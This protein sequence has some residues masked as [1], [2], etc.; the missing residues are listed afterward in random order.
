MKLAQESSVF[1]ITPGKAIILWLVL[2]GVFLML[3]PR[4]FRNKRA[5]SGQRSD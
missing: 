3:L 5:R 4:I 2:V 1:Q